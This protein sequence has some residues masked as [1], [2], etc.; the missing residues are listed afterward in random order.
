MQGIKLLRLAG[1]KR[2]NPIVQEI[3]YKAVELVIDNV[4]TAVMEPFDIQARI[5]FD[6]HPYWHDL[7]FCK[8]GLPRVILYL[9]PK[10]FYVMPYGLASVVMLEEVCQLNQGRF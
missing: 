1:L 6:E 2:T 5:C 3:A 4:E 9:T 7:V 10:M 8:Q